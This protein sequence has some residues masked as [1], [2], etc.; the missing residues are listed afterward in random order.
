M[1]DTPETPI[2]ALTDPTPD[3]PP[4]SQWLDVWDQFRKHKGALWG[5]FIL[6]FI[7]LGV[8]LGPFIWQVDPQKLDIRAKD[9]RPIY[10]ALWDGDAKTGWHRPLGT[11]NLGRDILANIIAGGRASMAVGWAAMILTIFLGTF[12][13]VTADQAGI[14]R[15]CESLGVFYERVYYR[16][17]KILEIEPGMEIPEDVRDTYLINHA[18]SV[19]LL[20][21]EGRL[22]AIFTPPHDPQKII[23]DL[24]A[25]QSNRET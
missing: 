16:D 6:A 23:D 18:S 5:G 19:F 25:M 22:H 4:R 12:I 17:G 7:T 21:P 3:S 9:M 1:S 11:D 15:L 20:N 2:G 14:D 13:G 8:L 10:V 24:A